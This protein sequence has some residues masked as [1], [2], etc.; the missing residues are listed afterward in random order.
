M[1]VALGAAG[2]SS[3][4]DSEGLGPSY[5]SYRAALGQGR[6]EQ[7]LR[8]LYASWGETLRTRDPA[9]AL[10]FFRPDM[11]AKARNTVRM[12]LELIRTLTSFRGT[13]TDLRLLGDRALLK[14]TET[15]VFRFRGKTRTDR[16]S[17]VRQ[18]R[19]VNGD[20][21]FE[22]PDLGRVRKKRR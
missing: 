4:R 13:I 2:C 8:K 19:L 21:Y 10:R 1:V 9:R 12:G 7:A 3:T 18:L 22:P 6:L 16:R 20:W 14:T 11:S 15:A 17:R 5:P